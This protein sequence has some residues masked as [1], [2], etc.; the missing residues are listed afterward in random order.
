VGMA[1]YVWDANGGF[2][3]E[4]KAAVFCENVIECDEEVNA[5]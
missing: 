1:E 4:I 5:S 3:L 2:E